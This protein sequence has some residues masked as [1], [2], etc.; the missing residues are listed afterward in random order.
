M[1][2]TKPT[3]AETKPFVDALRVKMEEKEKE[4]IKIDEVPF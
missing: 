2:K 4:K 3:R 1:K